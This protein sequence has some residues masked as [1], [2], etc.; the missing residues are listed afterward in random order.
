MCRVCEIRPG[1]RTTQGKGKLASPCLPLTKGIDGPLDKA[2]VNSIAIAVQFDQFKH[3]C[4]ELQQARR[5][6]GKG[7]SCNGKEYR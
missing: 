5:G 2:T 4:N 6:G 7:S 1:R 3:L